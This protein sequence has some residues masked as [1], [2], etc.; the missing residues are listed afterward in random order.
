VTDRRE[1][2]R[3]AALL[4]AW[5]R[6]VVW[7]ACAF[8]FLAFVPDRDPHS[9]HRDDP[10]LVHDLGWALDVLARWDSYWFVA[11][12]RDGY[13]VARAAPAFYPLY[14]G[15]V[16]VLGRA[17]LGHYVLAGLLVSLAATLAAFAL[18]AR[19]G[20][21]L[22]DRETAWRAVLYLAVFPMSI[23]LQ[24]VYSE[25]L[26]LAL[27]V[28]AF[29]AAEQRR[30]ALAGLATGLALLARPTGVAVLVGV[31]ILAWQ[32]GRAAA[33]VRTAVALP[34]FAAFPLVLAAAGRDPL[35]FLH[36][37]RLWYRETATF[38]PFGGLLEAL[39]A[40]WASVLQLTVGSKEHWYWV[41]ETPDRFAVWNLEATAFFAL[42]VVLTVIAWRRLG[43]A[44]GAFCAVSLAAPLAA[45]T[46]AQPLLSMPRFGLVLF[47]L[48]LALATLG[49]RPAVDR[50]IVGVSAVLL[51]VVCVQWT[52]WQWV[53]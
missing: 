18:L 53:S 30:F 48:F 15:A 52:L 19:L 32:R 7:L 40:A 43:A 16:A 8:A 39:R 50:A 51:G 26:F 5:S 14:P 9:I 6:G 22:L 21:V 36:V 23:F 12:A 41:Q 13:D 27:A 11:I 17:L 49:R 34:V 25:S 1:T 10:H 4:V 37:E 24:V 35:A 3:R 42:Y 38:G 47:P 46:H 44:Y 20:E 45:P 29:L 2:I 33:V 31:A 28:G